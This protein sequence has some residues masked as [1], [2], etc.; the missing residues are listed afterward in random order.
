MLDQLMKLIRDNAGDSIINNPAIPNERNEEAI[1]EA[2]SSI[3]GGL[4][5]LLAGGGIQQVLGMFTNAGNANNGN[6]VVQ[7]L[8][9]GFMDS[10]VNKFGLDRSQA[11]GIAGS[12][13][14][15]VLGQLISKTNNPADNS[16]NIQDIF[17]NLSGGRSA[18]INVE[19][20][21]G[22]LSQGGMDKDGDGDVDLKDLAAA[23]SGG[24]SS[25]GGVL[26]TLKGMFGR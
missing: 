12:L 1:Q 8:S 22:R 26:D 11:S 18:G 5:G 3:V 19:G 20:L 9:G 14:P 25:G 15:S 17:N 6:P 10:L 7:Q 21:M 24:G 23:F 13:L 16:F 2:G 4:Q